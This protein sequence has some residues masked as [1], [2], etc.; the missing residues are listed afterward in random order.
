MIQ[1]SF[2]IP[3]FNRVD[4][5]LELLD[6]LINMDA[7][8]TKF[9]VIVIN[10]GSTD[11][12]EYALQEFA[13]KVPFTYF[14]FIS[15]PNGGPGAARNHGAKIA[16]GKWL[17]FL[18]DDCLVP[19]TFIIYLNSSIHSNSDCSAACGNIRGLGKT[20]LS[21]YIDWTGL[22]QSPDDGNGY[23]KYFLTANAIIQRS[24]FL[25]VGGFNK[26]FKYASGEDVF[27]SEIIRKSG[28]KIYFFKDCVVEHKHRDSLL[29]IYAT[30][31]SYGSGHFIIEN[32]LGL[33]AKRNYLKILGNEFVRSAI[34]IVR[35]KSFKYGSIYLLLDL[36]KVFAWT[37]GYNKA[38]DSNKIKL[39]SVL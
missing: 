21:R 36:I 11:R 2:I 23:K 32:L 37:L 39:S 34:R 29:G 4:S 19:I 35:S 12:T 13:R 10:D 33:D 3:T 26:E 20:I 5:I 8:N 27:L 14:N 17:V 31:K 30:C 6:S 25:K 38:F 1:Y 18:D 7:A 15:V 16:N 28:Y 22:M 24:L 9:E